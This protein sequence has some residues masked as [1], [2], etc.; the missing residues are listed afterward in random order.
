M[1]HVG[2]K[3]EKYRLQNNFFIISDDF[4]IKTLYLQKASVYHGIGIN[5]LP[6][7]Y[8]LPEMQ[9]IIEEK[10]NNLNA[11]SMNKVVAI[12][13]VVVLALALVYLNYRNRRRFSFD[14]NHL[15]AAINRIFSEAGATVLSKAD[16]VRKL[17]QVL[18]CT[19]KEALFLYGEARKKNMIIAEN[20]EVRPTA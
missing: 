9:T 10:P 3:S 16:F 11:C 17:K 7:A 20:K 12:I 8:A 6:G 14:D 4:S 18:S 1:F 5:A 2:K 15:H 13:I 19:Q